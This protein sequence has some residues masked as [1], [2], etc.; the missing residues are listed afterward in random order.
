MINERFNGTVK[1]FE[2]RKGFGFITR[3]DK[4]E[5]YFVH[6]SSILMDAEYKLLHENQK[7]TFEIGEGKKGPCAI[8]VRI[9]EININEFYPLPA[10]VNAGAPGGTNGQGK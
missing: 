7:V 9:K 6:H 8:N 3:D 4:N 1:W 5:D 2:A 10:M